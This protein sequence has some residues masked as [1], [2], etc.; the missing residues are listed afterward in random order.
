M[1]KLVKKVKEGK[2]KVKGKLFKKDGS[3]QNQQSQPLAGGS[4][5]VAPTLPPSS[6][7]TGLDTVWN[8]V[9]NLLSVAKETLDVVPVP[10][11]KSAVGGFLEVV[12]QLKQVS[13]NAGAI[14]QL[15][16]SVEFFNQ[17]VSKPLEQFKGKGPVPPELAQA[18]DDLSAD[19]DKVVSPLRLYLDRG[20]VLQWADHN[21]I[22]GDVQAAGE[23]IRDAVRAFQVCILRYL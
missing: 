18:I 19:L 20:L 5:T 3:S 14:R 23:G 2:E 1:S 15:E 16:N 7:E 17:S 12:N 10:G 8:G 4:L 11:L 21:K 13:G 6:Q 9:L 22:G